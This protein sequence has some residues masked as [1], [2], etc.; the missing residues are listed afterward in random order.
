VDN[1]PYAA[2]FTEGPPQHTIPGCFAYSHSVIGSMDDLNAAKTPDVKEFFK[3]YYAPN[4][5]TLTIVGDFAADQAKQLIRQFFG[6]IP[7]GAE[8]PA[9]SCQVQFGAGEQATTW[10]DP[11]ANLPAVLIATW[12]PST[13]PRTHRRCRCS[14]HPGDEIAS[15][16]WSGSS[17]WRS[18]RRVLV[19]AAAPDSSSASPSPARARRGCAR[20]ACGL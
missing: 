11:L 13:R 20:A 18:V 1:Q 15:T 3:L 9:P 2:A 10:E 16:R 19:S 6:D 7:R 14:D 8:P 12:C 4:N 17:R 5:A